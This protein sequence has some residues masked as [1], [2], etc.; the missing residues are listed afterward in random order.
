MSRTKKECLTRI[1]SKFFLMPSCFR[2]Q[3]M[4]ILRLS[5]AVSMTTGSWVALEP[6]SEIDRTSELA[7]SVLSGWVWPL[8]R[9]FLCLLEVRWVSWVS[10]DWKTFQ[11][12][13]QV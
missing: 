7:A 2:L 1:W 13:L 11:Q 5:I 12:G 3:K 10:L 6:P 9:V 8:L 4:H